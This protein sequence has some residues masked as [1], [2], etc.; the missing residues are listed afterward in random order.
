[1][2]QSPRFKFV[3]GIGAFLVMVIAILVLTGIISPFQESPL[4]GNVTVW[5][6]SEYEDVM[7]RAANIWRARFPGVVLTIEARPRE[8]YEINLLNA[9]AAGKGPD[10]FMVDHADLPRFM[11]K[12][13]PFSAEGL[14][15]EEFRN[16]A[17]DSLVADLVNADSQLLG[18]P[19][20]LDTL[21]LYYN[22]DHLNAANLPNPPVTW[23]EF[24]EQSILLTE[25]SPSGSISRS[26]AAIGTSANVRHFA[27]IFATLILQTGNPLINRAT[28]EVTLGDGKFRDA[29]GELV[30][31]SALQFY[32]SFA[33]PLE[34]AYTWN[35]ALPGS[36]EAFAL[37]RASFYIGYASDL[38][39]IVRAN[40]HLNFRVAQL[41]QLIRGERKS[42]AAYPAMVV[43]RLSLAPNLAWAFAEFQF[44]AG[45]QKFVAEALG[46][47]PA[48]RDLATSRPPNPILSPFYN[49]VL[50]SLSW[51]APQGMKVEKIF[52][53][54]I[55]A[56][57]RAQSSPASA[58]DRADTQLEFL[59]RENKEKQ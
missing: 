45:T 59:M 29:R 50:S 13:L 31:T 19:V 7:Q 33:N 16:T 36:L 27:D 35:S 23:E 11:D 49:Q 25:R 8:D 3:A 20:F 38:Q 30:G 48:R 4:S 18:V 40:P 39:L 52:G 34:K 51:A 2:F 54:M 32:T 41:P 21:A 15:V 57:N 43:S 6:F 26:G 24:R 9:L 47:A 42:I 12:I 10:V 22:R 1:M 58:V 14:F 44:S 53:D 17:A 56:V 55:D 28:G 5:V 37:G 46:L